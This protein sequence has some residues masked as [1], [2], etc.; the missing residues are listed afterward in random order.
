MPANILVGFATEISF[1][2]ILVP[3]KMKTY[4][5]SLHFYNIIIL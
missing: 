1:A 4:K 2:K 5:N 3:S